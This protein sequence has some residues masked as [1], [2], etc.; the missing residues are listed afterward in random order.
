MTKVKINRIIDDYIDRVF[1][2]I[3]LLN[4]AERYYNMLKT[5]FQVPIIIVSSLMSILN[6]NVINDENSMRIVNVSFNVITALVLS[7]GNFLKINEKQAIFYISRQKFIKLG[8]DIEKKVIEED[9]TDMEFVQSI[10]SSYN[11]IV[12]GIIYDIPK[13][14]CDS[15]RN[16]YKERK[17]LPLIINGVSKLEIHRSKSL[18]MNMEEKKE[19]AT[20]SIVFRNTPRVIDAKPFIIDLQTVDVIGT[21]ECI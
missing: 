4:N 5:L 9:E 7:L 3:I 18:T 1:V 10:I 16:E 15:V 19:I 11:N 12:E 17:T 2:Y 13:S 20:S 8:T 6:S 14:I 21:N